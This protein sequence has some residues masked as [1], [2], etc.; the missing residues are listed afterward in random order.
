MIGALEVARYYFSDEQMSL[1]NTAK[2]FGLTVE[3]TKVLIVCALAEEISNLVRDTWKVR[4]EQPT[5][6]PKEM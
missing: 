5:E 6:E 3:R 1:T 4:D 2:R